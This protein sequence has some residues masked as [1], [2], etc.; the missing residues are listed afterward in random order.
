MPKKQETV[1]RPYRVGGWIIPYWSVIA[2][3]RR[4]CPM[5]ELSPDADRSTFAG[6][7]YWAAQKFVMDDK[8]FGLRARGPQASL[9]EVAGPP[10]TLM[11]VT[12]REAMYES[13][14]REVEG[15]E[16]FQEDSEFDAKMKKWLVEQGTLECPNIS[17]HRRLIYRL[18]HRH[19]GRRTRVP[20]ELLPR[21]G[22][23]F[24]YS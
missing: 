8:S 5:Y 18:L 13:D 17:R 22:L 12:H 20:D 3:G 2:W 24:L 11:L 7:A 14:S 6:G 1:A 15:L 23:N 10:G 21:E 16:K 19:P 4:I 9:E